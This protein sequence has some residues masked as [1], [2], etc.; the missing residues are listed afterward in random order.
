[1]FSLLENLSSKGL[2]TAAFEGTQGD[3]LSYEEVKS[4]RHQGMFLSRLGTT[5]S[6]TA[7]GLT[8]ATLLIGCSSSN[9][10]S[11][12]SQ[13]I[14]EGPSK[15]II[16][17]CMKAS[18][19]EGCVKVMTGGTE[20]KSENKITVDLDK[21]RNTGNV[22]PSGW[23]YLGGGYCQLVSC[24][25]LTGGHDPRLSG[26]AW[27]CRKG[28]L[29]SSVLRFIGPTV[30]ST[31]D[32]RC[33]LEEPEI[34]RNNSC[35]NGFSEEEINQGYRRFRLPFAGQKTIGFGFQYLKE[36]EG[37]KI[38][39]VIPGSPFSKYKI[40]AEDTIT[41]MNNLDLSGLSQQ[42]F[43][44][45]LSTIKKG[46]KTSFTIKSNDKESIFQVS[47]DQYRAPNNY[48]FIQKVDLSN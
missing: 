1:M 25:A 17:Q 18:D 48:S 47:K 44:E 27:A 26:K 24:E 31:T 8:L 6:T 42:E 11:A 29:G 35:T 22:C 4:R 9:D 45:K 13:E 30:R 14:A 34:G 28:F 7:L 41:H 3:C 21:I 23:G 10:V 15:K 40:F 32:E 38:L 39:G 20:S 16:D 43:Q 33:P 37:F 36:N 46:Q 5:A 2:L 19:F 12:G